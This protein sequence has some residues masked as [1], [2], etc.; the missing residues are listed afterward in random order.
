M[1]DIQ[2]AITENRR[3]KKDRNQ[4]PIIMA[5]RVGRP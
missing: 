5:C 2:S 3:G 4:W 1:V